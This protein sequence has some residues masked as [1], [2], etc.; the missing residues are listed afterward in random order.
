[1][2]STR[3]FI[4][5]GRAGEAR[6]HFE[7][8]LALDPT[9]QWAKQGLVESIKASNPIYA[10]L[11]R[12][13]LWLDRLPPR[14]RWLYIL[15]GLFVVRVMRGIA[16]TNPELAPAVYP[17]IGLW[18]AF[19]VA[20]WTAV[21][22]SNFILSR[23]ALG[24]RLVTGDDLVAANTVAGLLAVALTAGM[25]AFIGGSERMVIAALSAGF[26]IIPVS[27]IFQCSRGWPRTAMALYATVIAG[28]AVVGVMG[29]VEIGRTSAGIV[30]VMS[31]LG[32]WL[33]VFLAS[34]VVAAPMR[35]RQ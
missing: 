14:T 10:T 35:T 22:L 3:R 34:R 9:S 29:S 20:S 33:G 26:L 28:V 2:R 15:G 31:V 4:E 18:I 5:T 32:S 11:L 19:V 6:E 17:V 21:P 1:M 25:I 23:T 16:R 8:A 24:R 12:G 7:Q 27:A 30:V 13:F